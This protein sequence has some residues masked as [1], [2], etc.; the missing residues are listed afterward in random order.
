MLHFIRHARCIAN[1]G[2]TISYTARITLENPMPKLRLRQAT[3]ISALF[4]TLM[5]TACVSVKPY[6]GYTGFTVISESEQ[7]FSY[8]TKTKK[9]ESYAVQQ[10]QRGCARYFKVKPT[11]ITLSNV[12]SQSKIQRV[13]MITKVPIISSHDGAFFNTTS[14]LDQDQLDLKLIEATATC[15]V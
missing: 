11:Q 8:T 5:L 12:S 4:S 1:I 10:L 2:R 13:T 3:T 6:D 14:A 15:K 9:G 7:K